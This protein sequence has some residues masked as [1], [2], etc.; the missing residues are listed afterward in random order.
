MLIYTSFGESIPVDS[1]LEIKAMM[2]YHNENK[3]TLLDWWTKNKVQAEQN[4][5]WHSA[6]ITLCLLTLV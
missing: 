5:N 3:N 2:I 6:F 1:G 4:K